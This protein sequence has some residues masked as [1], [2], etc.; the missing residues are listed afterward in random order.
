MHCRFV[1]MWYSR[2]VRTS[3]KRMDSFKIEQGKGCIQIMVNLGVYPDLTREDK[4]HIFHY[5]PSLS[6]AGPHLIDLT[7]NHNRQLQSRRLRYLH[8]YLCMR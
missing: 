4:D 3:G 1:D 7:S 8:Q 6:R 5:L 2:S